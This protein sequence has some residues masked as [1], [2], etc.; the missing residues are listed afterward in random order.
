MATGKLTL[1]TGKMGAGK[2]TMSEVIAK[3]DNAVLISE[4]AWLSALFPNEIQVVEDYIRRSNLIKPQ[5]KKLAQDILLTGTN[6]VLDYPANTV[7]QRVWLKSIFHEIGAPHEL[8][9][10]KI[11]DQICLQQIEKRRIKHPERA[12]TDTKEMFEIMTKYFQE[13]ELNEGFNVTIVT[14]KTIIWG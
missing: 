9:Y 6:L 11:P 2:S 5:M 12:A 13:P 10:L 14:A 4:D 8:L 1:F 7:T 3:R